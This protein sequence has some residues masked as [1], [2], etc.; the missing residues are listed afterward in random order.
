MSGSTAHVRMSTLLLCNSTPQLFL[1][2]QTKKAL[3][4][5]VLILKITIKKASSQ[6]DS[7]CFMLP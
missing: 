6:T 4:E 7:E 3:S 5:A 2:Q 1:T